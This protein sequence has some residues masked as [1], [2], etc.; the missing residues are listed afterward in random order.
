MQERQKALLLTLNC[1]NKLIFLDLQLFGDRLYIRIGMN[2]IYEAILLQ[3]FQLPSILTSVSQ[4]RI[5]GYSVCILFE[6]SL[7]VIT[8]CPTTFMCIMN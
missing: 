7:C 2:T 8:V 5:I 1:P 4:E 3:A 6:F